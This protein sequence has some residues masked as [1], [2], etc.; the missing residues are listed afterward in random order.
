[1][2]LTRGSLEGGFDGILGQDAGVPALGRQPPDGRGDI[3][4]RDAA[5]CG[6]RLPIDE[7]GQQ[8]SAGDGGYTALRFEANLAEASFFNEHREPQ[9]VPADRIGDLHGDRRR[10]QFPGVARVLEMVK[11]RSVMHRRSL[12]LAFRLISLSSLCSNTPLFG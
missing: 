4:G 10:R 11:Y 9:D 8:R 5:R 3:E 7:F 1:M 12:C 2:S 6:E